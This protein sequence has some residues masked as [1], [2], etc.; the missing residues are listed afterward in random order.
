M[1]TEMFKIFIG[2]AVAL[3]SCGA[4]AGA[5]GPAEIAA[6]VEA[7]RVASGVSSAALLLVEGEQV[8]L[9]RTF[10]VTDWASGR[11]VDAE[12]RYK[13]GSISKVFTGIAL[14]KAE[15]RGLLRL[16]QPLNE[17]LAVPPYTNPWE[18]TRPL[19]TAM[20]LEH[21]AGWYDMSRAEF[22][23]RDP[24]PLTLAE[25]LALSPV[26]RQSH[27]P[28]GM[29]AEY[30]NSGLGVAAYVLEQVSGE[31]FE[32]FIDREVFR[33]LGMASATLLLD[34]PTR[35]HLVQGYDRDGKTPIPYWHIVY[36][37][38]G[39]LNLR[40]RDMAPFLSMLLA[41]GR[42]DGRPYLSPAQV[43]RLE[44]PTTTLAAKSGL[45]YG[46]GL[47]IYAAQHHGHTLYT[48]G[49]DGDGYLA[50]FAYSPA[51]GRGYFIVI[52]AFN[53]APLN[54]MTDLAADWLVAPLP[55]VPEPPPAAIPPATLE[56]WR[57][58][59]RSASV[60]FPR[61]GW[62]QRRLKIG[63]ADGL[64]YTQQENGRRRRLIPVTAHHFRRAGQ[65]TATIALLELED[66]S[67]VLQTPDGNWLAPPRRLSSAL[68]EGADQRPGADRDKTAAGDDAEPARVEPGAE[69]ASGEHAERR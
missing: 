32:N 2:G 60:R 38:A 44:T 27:W 4:A 35:A 64:L 66:G 40:P 19:T 46:Y 48:H 13:V 52:T 36:R 45:D 67:R 8:V 43:R 10:G 20:L 65:T 51:A 33:P 22:D 15:A 54:A 6:Q 7:I 17:L 47:G 1:F 12:S 5:P 14:L 41:H 56:L 29:Y 59:Y 9:D 28:P 50:R 25:A 30:S 34:A 63:S 21:T 53:H 39:G 55:P 37:P 24:Q 31:R 49:G 61:P 58:W 23:S 26:S 18:K 68:S 3:S 69:P 42:H 62:D 57:G 16:D 11:P